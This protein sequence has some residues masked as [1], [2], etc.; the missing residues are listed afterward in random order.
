[1]RVLIVLALLCACSKPERKAPAQ[2]ERAA[3][4]RLQH[5]LRWYE[6][7]PEA[8]LADAAASKKLLFVDLWAAWCHTCSS[9]REYVLTGA[10]L[11][12][13]R[14]RLLFLALDTERASNAP[15]LV[16]LPIAAW[17]TFYLL[18]GEHNVYGR[19]V[20]AAS[21]AQLTAFVRD[22][23]RA[24]DAHRKGTLLPND[25]LALL[26]EGDRQ[27]AREQ[28]ES[29]RASYEKALARAPMDWSR[30]AD[31]WA[32]LAGTLRKLGQNEGCADVG[33]RGLDQTGRSASAT[34]F[35]YWVLDCL[36]AL[37]GTDPRVRVL[38]KR[39]AERLLSLC[40][41]GDPALTPDDRG[42]ACGLLHEVDEQLGDA[43]GARHAYVLRLSVLGAAATGMPDQVAATYDFA[44]VESL[45]AL[46]RAEEAIALLEARAQALPDDYNPP[47][48]LARV[49]RELGRFNEGLAPVER[50]LALAQGP[51]RA[52]ILG[53]RADLLAGAG[54]KDE[55]R[56]VL[57]EQLAAYRALPEGQ[58]Q[59]SR[60]AAVAAKLAAP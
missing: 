6:D 45:L 7:A 53:V 8:A 27:A 4:T 23:L 39:I 43:G 50:A 40:E 19:W 33:L 55:A 9:M 58:K 44:R 12:D 24:F 5:G 37:P 25:P 49:Y 29:A 2:S 13:T 56:A 36:R 52:G 17:P 47:H 38:Q 42:D 10:N 1:M 46:G 3:A 32:A 16:R 51:R 41:Q 57:E 48:Q 59:P 60:E 31:V 11:G 20:G 21:P 35:S 54:R 14:D 30:R 18:D 34:D 15:A 28:L 22:G 26:L